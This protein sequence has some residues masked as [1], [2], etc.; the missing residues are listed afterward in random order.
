MK[1][2]RRCFKEKPL[3]EFYTHKGMFDGHL[4]ICKDCIKKRVSDHS[5]T[6]RGKYIEKIRNKKESRRKW[7]VEYQRVIRQRYPEKYKARSI[8]GHAISSGI[9]IKGTCEVCGNIKVEAHHEDYS[10]PL[11]VKWLCRKHHR[12]IHTY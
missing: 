7:L 11:D 10:K 4:N 9:V 5:K 12:D 1:N 2:C 8:L 3:D 6:R